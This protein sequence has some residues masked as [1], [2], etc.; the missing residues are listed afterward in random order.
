M[1]GT[2]KQLLAAI[3][4]DGIP[5]GKSTLDRYC[6]PSINGGGPPVAGWWGRRPLYDLEKGL[7]WARGLLTA[8][9]VN[10]VKAGPG[11]AGRKNA[12]HQ[13]QSTP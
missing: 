7:A 8:E 3:N 4:D 6:M 10:A 11:R 12:D 1:L 9:P 5:M 13:H 2:R